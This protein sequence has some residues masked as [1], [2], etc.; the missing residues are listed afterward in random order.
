MRNPPAETY[1]KLYSVGES[2]VITPGKPVAL[3]SLPYKKT[4]NVVKPFG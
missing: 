1:N 3:T 2:A 4:N